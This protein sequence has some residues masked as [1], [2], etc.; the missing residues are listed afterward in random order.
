[1]ADGDFVPIP[2]RFIR[3]GISGEKEKQRQFSAAAFHRF[4]PQLALGRSSAL[5]FLA[6]FLVWSKFWWLLRL[7]SLFFRPTLFK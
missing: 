1:M 7:H 2:L 6:A 5:T 4:I 3:M